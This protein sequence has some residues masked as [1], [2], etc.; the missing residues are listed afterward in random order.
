MSTKRSMFDLQLPFFNA[1]WR[2]VA[3]TAVAGLWSVL[4]FAFASPLFGMIA[5][6]VAV[7]CYYDFFLHWQGP[8]EEPED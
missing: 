1:R 7:K 2:R 4:E 5:G 6:A 8:Y 3:V